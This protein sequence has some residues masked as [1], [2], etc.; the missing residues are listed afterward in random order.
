MISIKY[1]VAVM[2]YF[3]RL[4][5][6]KDINLLSKG[7]FVETILCNLYKTL[8]SLNFVNFIRISSSRKKSVEQM[9]QI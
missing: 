4:Y 6:A 2:Y 9:E 7:F 5:T 3:V 1:K 8:F